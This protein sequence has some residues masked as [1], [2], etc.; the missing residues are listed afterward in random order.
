MRIKN[1]SVGLFSTGTVIFGLGLFMGY[2][3][4]IFVGLVMMVAGLLPST[5]QD[6]EDENDPV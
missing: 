4:A 1:H 2:G 5:K 3:L 6:P